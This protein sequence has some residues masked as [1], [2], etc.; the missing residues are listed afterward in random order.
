MVM[1]AKYKNIKIN[2][3]FY[4]EKTKLTITLK[5]DTQNPDPAINL[6]ET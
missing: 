4:D 3:I 2:D 1:K 5:K 6:G